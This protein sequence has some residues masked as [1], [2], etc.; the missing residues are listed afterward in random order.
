MKKILLSLILTSFI[1]SSYA[2]SQINLDSSTSKLIVSMLEK[3]KEA[4]ILNDSINDEIQL[5]LGGVL[6]GKSKNNGASDCVLSG[7][8]LNINNNGK[9]I[10]ITGDLATSLYKL[11]Q[12]KHLNSETTTIKCESIDSLKRLTGEIAHICDVLFL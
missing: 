1:S 10:S 9:G 3:S 2:E 7:E 12:N 8:V 5:D 11:I 6:C 4:D